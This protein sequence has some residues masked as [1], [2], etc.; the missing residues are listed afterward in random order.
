MSSLRSLSFLTL[1]ILLG[2]TNCDVRRN[3]GHI[4]SPLD[5]SGAL[6]TVLTGHQ[7]QMHP[8]ELKDNASRK[9]EREE[10]ENGRFPIHLQ[11]HFDLGQRRKLEDNTT[12]VFDGLEEE[13]ELPPCSDVLLHE[14]I[15]ERCHHA[16]NCEGEYIMTTLLPLAFCNHPS[17]PSPIDAHPILIIFFPVL[18]PMS[19]LILT[20]LLFRLLGSTAEN[21]FSP[22]L[23]MISSEFRIVE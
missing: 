21:Y 18:F 2:P 19:L 7:I 6:L 10:L 20:L 12:D 14:T 4:D 3:T 13:E 23:E 15:E 11:Y 22:A 16:R 17:I 9:K 8:E 5:A 1:L